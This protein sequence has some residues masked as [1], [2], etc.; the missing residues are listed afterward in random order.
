LLDV[1]LTSAF[2]IFVFYDGVKSVDIHWTSAEIGTPIPDS[3][4]VLGPKPA[5]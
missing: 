5:G 2:V 1:N 3:T 4:F